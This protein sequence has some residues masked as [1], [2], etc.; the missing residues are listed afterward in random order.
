MPRLPGGRDGRGARGPGS[1]SLGRR[2]WPPTWLEGH[3]AGLDHEDHQ[4][5]AHADPRGSP[6]HPESGGPKRSSCSQGWHALLWLRGAKGRRGALDS[7]WGP[8]VLWS[9]SRRR[10][11]CA[12]WPLGPAAAGPAWAPLG[13]PSSSVLKP[14]LGEQKGRQ[15]HQK[16]WPSRSPTVLAPPRRPFHSP[17]GRPASGLSGPGRLLQGH[18]LQANPLAL[19]NEGCPHGQ[20]RP[21]TLHSGRRLSAPSLPP[22][23]PQPTC[24]QLQTLGRAEPSLLL[25]HVP[26]PCAGWRT[27]LDARFRDSRLTSQFLPGGNP[28]EAIPREGLHEDPGLRRRDDCPLSPGLSGRVFYQRKEHTERGGR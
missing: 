21:K 5:L 2:R 4:R 15:A 26:G 13:V 9:R 6:G 8:S 18:F 24:I 11:W 1:C 7:G 17:P 25:G 19:G 16:P 12:A 28:R 23:K 20:K 10:G 3:R 27:Y 22:R 14:Y